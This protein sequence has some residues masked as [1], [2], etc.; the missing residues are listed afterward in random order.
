MFDDFLGEFARRPGVDGPTDLGRWRTGQIDDLDNLFGRKAAWGARP[1][2]IRQ[3]GRDQRAQIAGVVLDGGELGI[4]LRP[5]AA[6]FA[7][8]GQATIERLSQRIIALPG[9]GTQH[10][11]H[12]ERQGLGTGGLAQ[13]RVEERLLGM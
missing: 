11:P 10:D 9:S 5:A 6:P 2:R 13:Q 8:G 12:T 3:N 1:R 4:G 7:H